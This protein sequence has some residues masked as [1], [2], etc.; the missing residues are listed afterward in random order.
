MHFKLSRLL[1]ESRFKFFWALP[2]SGMLIGLHDGRKPQ[3]LQPARLFETTFRTGS[4]ASFERPTES[5]LR[6]LSWY[7]RGDGPFIGKLDA[8]PKPGARNRLRG[9]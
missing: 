1:G 7:R 4:P 2:H 5:P 8:G 6:V 9:V 3:S